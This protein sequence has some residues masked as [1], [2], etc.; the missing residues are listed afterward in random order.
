MTEVGFH[1]ASRARTGRAVFLVGLKPP[2]D[3]LAGCTSWFTRQEQ[4]DGGSESVN[5]DQEEELR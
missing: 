3:P 5:R 1:A 4:R 2:I